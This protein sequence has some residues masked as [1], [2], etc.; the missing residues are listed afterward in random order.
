MKVNCPNC[1]QPISDSEAF[2]SGCGQ[3]NHLSRITIRSVALDIFHSV[4]EAKGLPK[5]IL[6]LAISPGKVALEYISGKQ[7][8]YFPPFSFLILVVGI[9]S[10]FLSQSQIISQKLSATQ[11]R[12]G[13]LM[14]DHANIIIF[15]N[16]PI[17]AFFNW[18]VFRKKGLN[19]GEH[20]ILVAFT[21]G[22]K[23]LFFS[24][25]IL[26]IV[27]LFPNL[28]F[29]ISSLYL[30]CWTIYFSWAN[31]EF[32]GENQ[33]G[34]RLKGLI[35]PIATQLFTIALIISFVILF[36]KKKDLGL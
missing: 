36:L 19:G 34:F 24:F 5:L 8:R 3:Q 33:I 10:F 12:A 20:L 15:L 16:V 25:I 35:P 14:N 2:C 32:H 28:Y 11:T 9:S 23:S 27:Y 30:V 4:T 6:R 17:L 21:S 22:M 18:T 7:K 31:A 26:P 29:P 1:D 13:T